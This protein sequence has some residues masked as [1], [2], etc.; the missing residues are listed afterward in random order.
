[1]P[2]SAAKGADE[3]RAGRRKSHKRRR[4]SSGTAGD[5]AVSKKASAARRRHGSED[6]RKSRTKRGSA[7]DDGAAGDEE[8]SRGG[9]RGSRSS[10]KRSTR[11]DITQEVANLEDRMGRRLTQD[12]M[13][14]I[15]EAESVMRSDARGL[16]ITAGGIAEKLDVTSLE[17][18]PDRVRDSDTMSWRAEFGRSRVLQVDYIRPV[19]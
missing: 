1:M 3:T 13:D 6:R 4:K 7:V 16:S 9:K 8:P 11:R 17:N 14:V 5:R 19:C 10:R 15:M 18:I 2:E 12:E